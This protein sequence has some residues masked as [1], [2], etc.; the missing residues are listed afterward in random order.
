MLWQRLSALVIGGIISIPAEIM[1]LG[2]VLLLP[3]TFMTTRVSSS[4]KESTVYRLSIIILLKVIRA[5]WSA[6]TV[7][8]NTKSWYE[9]R[10]SKLI[11]V[12]NVV[13]RRTNNG[14]I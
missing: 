12:T 5:W 4:S 1:F 7:A 11:S 2:L 6:Q 10:T 14:S 3:F 13:Q 8:E 9:K